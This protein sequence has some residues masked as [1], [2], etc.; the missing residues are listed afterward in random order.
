MGITGT[1][2]GYISSV[3]YLFNNG[4]WSNLQTT[5]WNGAG[6][7]IS[8]GRKITVKTNIISSAYTAYALCSLLQTFNLSNYKYIKITTIR[9]TS[10]EYCDGLIGISSRYNGTIND[11]ISSSTNASSGT[12]ILDI[13]SINGSYYIYIGMKYSAR[14]NKTYEMTVTQLYLT[15]S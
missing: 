15:N 1:F 10:Y 7:D 3:L 12:T 4:V 14:S 8:N 6:T 2:E 5:G 11:F 13:S 9:N